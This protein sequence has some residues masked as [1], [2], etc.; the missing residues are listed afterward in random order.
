MLAERRRSLLQALDAAADADVVSSLEA[1]A[2]RLSDE[3]ETT[4]QQA[5]ELDPA[6]QDV[7]AAEAEL[8]ARSGRLRRRHR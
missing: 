3:L 5:R 6:A 4:A 1:D 7:A 8:D 2:A